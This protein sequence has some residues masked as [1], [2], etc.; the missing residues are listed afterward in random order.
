MRSLHLILGVS[1]FA[2]LAMAVGVGCSSSSN[3]STPTTDGG[4]TTTC[5]GTDASL[6]TYTPPT[7]D[8]SFSPSAVWECVK[9]ACGSAVTECANDCTCN[10]LVIGDIETCTA[11]G[12]GGLA[13]CFAN[14]QSFEAGAEFDLTSCFIAN[15]EPCLPTTEAGAGGDGSTGTGDGATSTTDASGDGATS[16]TD[17]SGDGAT[18]TTDASGD[19][20]IEQ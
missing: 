5:E 7:I 12:L 3:K 6:A 13:A 14:I 2:S 11:T 8:A 4:G 20:A 18:S 10:S 9:A 17:A 19:G 1:A 16:T 15:A